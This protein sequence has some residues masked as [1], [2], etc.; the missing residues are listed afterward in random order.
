MP[1]GCWG[2]LKRKSLRRQE[3]NKGSMQV[4]SGEIPTKVF[5][6]RV[7]GVR[8]NKLFDALVERVAEQGKNKMMIHMDKK[9]KS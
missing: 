8:D 4:P 7:G 2:K 9:L 1:K 6:D 5:E 3:Q